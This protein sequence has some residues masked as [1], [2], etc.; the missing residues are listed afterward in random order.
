MDLPRPLVVTLQRKTRLSDGMERED[1]AN[2]DGRG[3][4]G[5]SEE[6]TL[7]Q[8]PGGRLAFMMKLTDLKEASC[9]FVYCLSEL[10]AEMILL[11]ASGELE[12][13]R[14]EGRNKRRLCPFVANVRCL[15]GPE[16][17]SSISLSLPRVFLYICVLLLN[18]MP[19]F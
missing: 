19:T 10:V 18:V 5:P 3:G 7:Q 17:L 8:R 11:L 2:V 1:G 9:F 6:M 14:E 12:E 16:A 4:E 15:Q 13:M